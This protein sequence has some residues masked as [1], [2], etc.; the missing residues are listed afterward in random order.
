MATRFVTTNECDAAPD[1]KKTYID[2]RREDL[3]IIKSPVG[4][5]GR[6]IRNRFIDDV[7]E[8]KRKPYTCPYHC[9]LTCDYKNT[10][11]C[12]AQ[13]LMNAKK[14]K[15]KNGF[16]FAG[17]N[18]FRE[19]GIVPVRTLMDSLQ[20]EFETAARPG[21]GTGWT[22]DGPFSGNAPAQ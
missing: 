20:D 19:K 8:G 7:S 6:A 4:M 14:G 22:P 1:F 12:I 2:A 21:A 11:Y 16:A 13:A 3:V 10:P 18:A 17:A 5:P 15:L 9:L